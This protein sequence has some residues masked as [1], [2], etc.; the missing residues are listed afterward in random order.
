MILNFLWLQV[1]CSLSLLSQFRKTYYVHVVA[2]FWNV[3]LAQTSIF[4][5]KELNS[6]I[7]IYC[8]DYAK[9]CLLKIEK[10]YRDVTGVRVTYICAINSSLINIFY[11][12]TAHRHC[13]YERAK[14][15]QTVTRRID[16]NRAHRTRSLM[17]SPTCDNPY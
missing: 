15:V 3:S 14:H 2:A 11:Y 9:F 17:E 12:Y 5:L 1:I 6:I 10:K 4:S 13:G 8:I 16:V 7:V